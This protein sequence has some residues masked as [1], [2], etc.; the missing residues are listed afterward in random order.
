MSKSGAVSA[1]DI[2]PNLYND[3]FS[4]NTNHEDKVD[5][6]NYDV[7]NLVSCDHHTLNVDTNDDIEDIILHAAT[8][9]SQLLIKR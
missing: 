8:R 3:T 2:L 7:Y 9:S 4:E 1:T 6:L 5:D